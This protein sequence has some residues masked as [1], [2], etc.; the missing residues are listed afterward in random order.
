[1]KKVNYKNLLFVP[2]YVAEAIEGANYRKDVRDRVCSFIRKLMIDSKRLN[3]D[4]NIFNYVPRSRN[5]LKKVLGRNYKDHLTPLLE[6]GILE[7]TGYSNIQNNYCRKYRI[8]NYNNI[9]YKLLVDDIDNIISVICGAL[10]SEALKTLGLTAVEYEEKV[11]EKTPNLYHK[12][13]VENIQELILDIERLFKI[14]LKNIQEV[15]IGGYTTNYDIDEDAVKVVIDGKEKYFTLEGAVQKALSENK[16]LIKDNRRYVI[17][18]PDSFIKR[19]KYQKLLSDME[20]LKALGEGKFRAHRNT[21]NNRLDTNLT[22]MSGY[23]LEAIKED[24]DLDAI[25]LCNSQFAISTLLIDLDTEDFERYK[26]VALNCNF[27]EYLEEELKLKDRAEAKTTCFEIMFSS[28]KNKSR[29]V[30]KFKS[31]FPTV[32]AW[33]ENFKEENGY[34]MFSINLQKKESEIFIDNL[35]NKLKD[36]FF[37][38]TVHDSIICRKESKTEVTNKIQEY[39]NEIGFEVCLR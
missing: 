15:N 24:N 4:S 11:N 30:K 28:H 13:F 39:F 1:M 33:I 27:Y 19:K 12:L 25:D 5:Y 10:L 14:S 20:S 29:R 3:D 23:L 2:G 34:E 36:E 9:E 21:T 8:N 26:Y 35:Y 38:F 16:M 22:N 17:E 6:L 32:M 31:L 7:Q 37:I 18:D